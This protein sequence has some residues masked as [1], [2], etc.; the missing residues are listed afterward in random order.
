MT[1]SLA[2]WLIIMISM[3]NFWFMGYYGFIG[4]GGGIVS[5]LAATIS[6]V[7]WDNG[8][9]SRDTTE[10]NAMPYVVTI[11]YLVVSLV[12]NT[13]FCGLYYL[14]YAKFIPIA[15]NL[16]LLIAFI[17]YRSFMEPYRVH[18]EQTAAEVKQKVSAHYNFSAVLS[19]IS[20]ETED[21]DEKKAVRELQ[22][23]V[24]YSPNI[25][26]GFNSETENS[27]WKQLNDIKAAVSDN[28][29]KELVLK[30]IAE[31]KKTWNRRNGTTAS[32]K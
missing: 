18:V 13:I 4:L 24:A 7:L 3:M 23:L 19:E 15:V 26:Q 21:A 8:A 9:P 17:A 12:V 30:E 1:L 32:I 6:L 27:F 29:D 28:A 5:F 20:A 22:E 25:S 10:I 2:A 14:N 31:A 16:I 11:L